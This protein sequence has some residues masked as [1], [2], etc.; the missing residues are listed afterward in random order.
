MLVTPEG[1][2]LWRWKYRFGGK[3]KQMASGKYPDVPLAD[4]RP[5]HAQARQLL[6]NGVDPMAV[7]KEVKQEKK[8]KKAGQTIAETEPA[9]P[10]F[11]TLAWKWFAWW[12]SDKKAGYVKDV[13]TRLEGDIIAKVGSKVPEDIT[14]LEWVTVIKAIDERGARDLARRALQNVCQIY[15]YGIDNGLLDQ[16]LATPAAGIRPEKDHQP[17][18]REALRVSLHRGAP[19]VASQDARLYRQGC[20]EGG[21]GTGESHLPP[22]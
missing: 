14:R 20:H 10:T 13:K 12:K 16:N 21:D 2:K 15:E 22:Y 9:G 17:G 4:A 3:Q 19:G 5:L 18:G 6:A 1:G 8:A 7:R 11:E